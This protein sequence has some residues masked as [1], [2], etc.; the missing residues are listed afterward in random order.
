MTWQAWNANAAGPRHT[1]QHQTV[2][3]VEF[4]DRF[5]KVDMFAEFKFS[6]KIKEMEEKSF[7]SGEMEKI[8][9]QR[10][11]ISVEWHILT[12]PRYLQ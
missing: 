8:N 7:L 5:L 1:S 2:K 4:Q 10:P 12:S 11:L 3:Y 6:I 9:Q